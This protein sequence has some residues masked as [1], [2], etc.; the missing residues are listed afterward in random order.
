MSGVLVARLLA[1]GHGGGSAQGLECERADAHAGVEGDGDAAEVGEFE[2]C[3]AGPT[4][5][6]ETGG[7]VDDDADAAEAGA[8]FEAAENVVGQVEGL[9]GYSEDEV[10]GLENKGLGFLDN[11]GA[12]HSLD[13]ELVARVDEGK[14]AVF[15]D[16]ELV[17]EPEINGTA[18]KVVLRKRRI[19]IDL[20]FGDVTPDIDIGKDH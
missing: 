13:G 14:A 6:E 16:A 18:P 15:K 1:V 5:I 19:Y 8:A 7:A 11:D 20:A 17:T 3:L 12:H 9:H 2:G 10:A 4:G